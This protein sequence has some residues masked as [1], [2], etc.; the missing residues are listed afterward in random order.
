MLFYLMSRHFIP[1]GS[2]PEYA[3]SIFL[4]SYHDFGLLFMRFVHFLTYLGISFTLE[5]NSYLHL[6][7]GN[8]V[9]NEPCENE[10]FV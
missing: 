3:I 8:K 4:C 10:A 7:F 6:S 5:Q 1:V 2:V 9:C